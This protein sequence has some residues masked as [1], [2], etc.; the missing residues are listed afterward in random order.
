[1]SPRLLVF[2]LLLTGALPAS[3]AISVTGDGFTYSQ[4]FDSLTRSTTAE[5]WGNDANTTS[6]A[7]SPRLVGLN[8]WYAGS[9]GTGATTPQIRAGTGTNTAG[10]FYS[11]GSAA[12]PG[13]RALGTL[14][15]DG[16]APT[17]MR[18]GARF[19]NNTGMTITGFTFTYTGE[20]WRKAQ[21]ATAVNNQYV[22]AYAVFDAGLGSLEN[23]GAYSGNISSA[24]FNTPIDGGDNLGAA[25]DGNAS[26]NRVT[27]LGGTI[28]DL[29]VAPGQEIWLR[30]F[31]SNSSSAD[32]G[33]AI[34][35]FTIGFTA[36][37]EPAA[38][39]FGGL[40]LLTLISRRRR[41]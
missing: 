41:F 10:S 39:L 1:M 5:N 22:V 24:T 28:A 19:V 23:A 3:A 36:V 9:Y 30:W 35:D 7:D 27:G 33:I 8:G 18:I 37:P 38:A 29:T 11:F 16:T 32:Q 14:P 26:A 34:D 6:T 13:D 20:Q 21:L 25:L 12:T 17:S 4:S 31:D 15:S 40:S 2:P